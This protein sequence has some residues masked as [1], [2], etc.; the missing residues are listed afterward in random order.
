LTAPTYGFHLVL[1]LA[2]L[3]A[4]A[5]VIVQSFR[6]AR[7]TR[8]R[9]SQVVG[10]VCSRSIRRHDC[11]RAAAGAIAVHRRA[12]FTMCE[13]RARRRHRDLR[14]GAL[15]MAITGIARRS[16]NGPVRG[17]RARSRCRHRAKRCSPHK[18]GISE[19]RAL[20]PHPSDEARCS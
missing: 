19:G 17:L 11:D 4:E 12:A 8:A 10:P 5:V 20:A 9:R 6:E 14:L 16:P 1:G 3:A 18:S 13:T 15:R 2:L 7:R